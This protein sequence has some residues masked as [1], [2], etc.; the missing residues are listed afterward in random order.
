MKIVGYYSSS[1]TYTVFATLQHIELVNVQAEAFAYVINH[2][3]SAICSHAMHMH[4]THTF[5]TARRLACS[6][7]VWSCHI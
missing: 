7:V 3:A 1:S 2:G 5:V 6:H 4:M